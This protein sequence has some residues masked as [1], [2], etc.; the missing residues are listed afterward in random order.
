MDVTWKPRT[1]SSLTLATRRYSTE[2]NGE[3]D[4][5]DTAE[6]EAHWYHLWNSRSSTRIELRA[7]QDEFIGSFRNDERYEAAANIDYSLR[8]W[9]DVVAGYRFEKRSS[10]ADNLSYTRNVFYLELKL[11]L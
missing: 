3:G 4:Y 11:S 5:V 2:T 9:V 10:D 6:Y 8:R 1:Y 7:S